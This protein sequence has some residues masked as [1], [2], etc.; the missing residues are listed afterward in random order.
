MPE[1]DSTGFTSVPADPEH[2]SMRE[3]FHVAVPL[4]LSAGTQSLMNAA[5]RII[6]AGCSE[7][8]LAAITPASM[9]H[10]TVVCVPVG[11]ILYA[12]TFVAQFDGARR[13]ERM[14]R[15]V[16][17]AIWLAG[18]CGL[19]LLLCL[20]FS[21]SALALSG[22]AP[23]IVE[24]EAQY[25]NT[26]CAGSPIYL[27][28]T[29][30][31][32]YFSGRRR[33]SVVMTISMIA[34]VFNFGMDY[35][36]V[37]GAGPF[38]EFGIRGAALATVLAR[39][40]EVLAYCVLIRRSARRDLMPFGAAWRPDAG[41]LRKFV[42][43]G[44]PSGLHH[45]LDNSGFTVFLLIVGNLSSR[46]LAATNVAFSV[47]GLIFVPL[48]GFGTAIQTLVGHHI[49]AGLLAAA[50]R[51]TWNAVVLGIA[52]TASTGCLL[53]AFPHLALK[54]FFLF[55]TQSGV[56]AAALAEVASKLLMFVAVYSVF[57]ALAVVFA[58][59]LRGAGDTV[60]PMLITLL[61]SWFVMV[62][63]ALLILNSSSPTIGKLWMTSAINIGLTGTCMLLRWMTGR[64]QQIHLLEDATT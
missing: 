60:F 4:M 64:W 22:H 23:E 36:L 25:F 17:Q 12:N 47:N 28:A 33:T 39:C 35:V 54:P 34:V 13:P 62:V 58:S 7:A 63:P 44:V 10:W 48:L 41:L 27:L 29:A 9:L 2:G 8:A 5:D 32:C 21:R 38:P 51:T 16:W 46:D 24:F 49:G 26:L 15:S 19:L 31:S 55:A 37:Y 56:D 3:L 53:V 61:S 40:W 52:W 43:F 59:A 18:V 20:P 6:V 57:D 11:A 14:M 45:F 50:K 42:R 1:P 30:L